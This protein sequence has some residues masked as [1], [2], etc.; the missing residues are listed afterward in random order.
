MCTCVAE[1]L[2]AAAVPATNK[3]PQLLIAPIIITALNS[4]EMLNLTLFIITSF[5]LCDMLLIN[6][7]LNSVKSNSVPQL[8]AQGKGR[9]FSEYMQ[10]QS[11][12]TCAN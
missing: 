9:G 2:T 4:N 7:F 12:P 8:T 1:E 10:I 6:V 5:L 3:A 11:P